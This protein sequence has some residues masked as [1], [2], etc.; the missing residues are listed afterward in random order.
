MLPALKELSGGQER[1]VFARN[2]NPMGRGLKERWDLAL[3]GSEDGGR[4]GDGARVG[5]VRG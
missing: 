1:R 2:S 4:V 5:M 3:P